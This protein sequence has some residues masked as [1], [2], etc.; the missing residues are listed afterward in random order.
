MRSFS[1]KTPT[2]RQIMYNKSSTAQL[3]TI[4]PETT[5]VEIDQAPHTHAVI[6]SQSGGS[7]GAEMGAND[8]GVCAGYTTVCTKVSATGNNAPTPADL[9]RLILERSESAKNGVEIT[10]SLIDQY[11]QGGKFETDVSVNHCGSFLIADKFEAWVVE[12][13]GMFWVAKQIK[14]GTY[15]ISSC[16]SISTDYDMASSDLQDNSVTSGHWSA[17]KGPVNF[18]VA[19]GVEFPSS[20]SAPDPIVRRRTGCDLLNNS[21]DQDSFSVMNMFEILRNKGINMNSQLITTGSQVSVLSSVGLP[22]CHWMTG[23]PD[24]RL[25]VFKPFIFSDNADIGDITYSLS[26]DNKRHVLFKYH[27]KA[28]D[29]MSGGSQSGAALLQLMRNLEGTCVS[30]MEEFCQKFSPE[31][32][33]DVEE[34][35][36]DICES[37]VKFYL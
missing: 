5:N 17:D 3:P 13:A 33:S 35:F 21:A 25:S 18:M 12:C 34:L 28:R 19:F 30:E 15:N 11:G 7:W 32:M 4:H 6:L 36:K 10:T 29:L 16:L 27:E 8:Q 37:E 1:V 14:D 24:P 26:S 23:T 20:L 31:N 2:C 9:T 22:D